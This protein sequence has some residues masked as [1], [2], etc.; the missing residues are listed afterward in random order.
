MKITQLR[1]HNWRR[2]SSRLERPVGV[3]RL[4]LAVAHR[5]GEQVGA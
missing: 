3:E 5:P 4:V 1:I 2:R